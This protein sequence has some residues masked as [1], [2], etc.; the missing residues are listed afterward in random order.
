VDDPGLMQLAQPDDER[1]QDVA[2]DLVL[3][4]RR[5]ALAQ[6][7]QEAATAGMLEDRSKAA[8]SVR[9]I[10]DA[11]IER[12]RQMARFDLARRRHE[13]EAR[14]AARIADER[15]ETLV[16]RTRKVR[17]HGGVETGTEIRETLLRI[18]PE[19]S[20]IDRG[21]AARMLFAVLRQ[22]HPRL[23]ALRHRA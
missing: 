23:A 11:P 19:P 5:E 4:D 22:D 10:N 17:P 7:R 1:R 14:L 21:L 16:R 12:C 18:E 20:E 2:H 6:T 8:P 15:H 13:V 9:P 3:A